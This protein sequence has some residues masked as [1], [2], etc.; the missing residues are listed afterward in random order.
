MKL[1]SLI[2][3]RAWVAPVAMVLGLGMGQAAMAQTKPLVKFT[4]NVG[5]FVVELQSDVAPATANHFLK[6]VTERVYDNTIFHKSVGDFVLQGGGFDPNFVEKPVR[7]RLVHEGQEV[8]ARSKMR[9]TAGT[10]AMARGAERNSA[11]NEF[12]I[13]LADNADLDPIAIPAGDPVPRFEFGGKVYSNVPRDRLVAAT[14]LYGYTPFARI[15]AGADTIERIKKIPT[16]K[17]GPFP[18]DVPLSAVVITRAEVVRGPVTETAVLKAL[19]AVPAVPTP[20]TAAAT[21]VA[22]TPAVPVAVNNSSAAVAEVTQALNRWAAAWSA[23]D[24][25]AYIA[26]YAPDYKAPGTKSRKDWEEQRNAR[27]SEKSKIS[28]KVDRVDVQVNGDTATA[29]FSQSYQADAVSS[30]AG[31]MLSFAKVGGRWLITKEEN[32]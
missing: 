4:T 3:L 9:N 14:E 16:G 11:A 20:G 13:N 26:A 12:F 24:V 27:I 1:P 21:V 30:N 15:V 2:N 17:V 29:K 31:K 22:N 23:K 7:A 19:P 32:R 25:P 8:V 6:N 18:S 28:L 5:E 10:L